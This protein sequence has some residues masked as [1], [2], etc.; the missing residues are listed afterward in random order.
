M[1]LFSCGTAGGGG[2]GGGSA[3][4]LLAPREDLVD[5]A[6]DAALAWLSMGSAGVEALGPC[7]SRSR[8]S[9]AAEFSVCTP[10]DVAC[11]DDIAALA[12]SGAMNLFSCGTAGG[13]GGGGKSAADLLVPREKLVDVAITD[14]AV[15]WLSTGSVGVE[16]LGAGVNRSRDPEAVEVSVCILVDVACADDV[17]AR[18]SSSPIGEDGGAD[19]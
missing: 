13:G 11:A 9:E 12:R 19:E 1:I 6:D 17:L 3:D 5:V 16:A 14:A 8:G 7:V 2:G 4:D 10:V 15:A 18:F